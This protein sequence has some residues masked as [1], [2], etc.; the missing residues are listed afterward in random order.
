MRFFLVFTRSRLIFETRWLIMKS[1]LLA[2]YF[3]EIFEENEID[4]SL[5]HENV[6]I[7]IAYGIW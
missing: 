7:W 2:I 4:D 5:T 3:E 6:S 1:R